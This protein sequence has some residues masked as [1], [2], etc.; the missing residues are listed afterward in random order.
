MSRG[1][2]GGL[3]RVWVGKDGAIGKVTGFG[4]VPVGMYLHTY[5][6]TYVHSAVE[7][8]GKWRRDGKGRALALGVG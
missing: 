4:V 5:L 8:E 2:T 3:P 6:H 1:C 7:R